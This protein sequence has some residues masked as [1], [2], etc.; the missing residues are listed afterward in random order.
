LRAPT[1][2]GIEIVRP[3]PQLSNRCLL[4][5][6]FNIRIARYNAVYMELPVPVVAKDSLLCWQYGGA[7]ARAPFTNRP[8]PKAPA[9]SLERYVGKFNNP[10]YGD[11]LVESDGQ[12]LWMTIGPHKLK[13]DLIHWNHDSF[14]VSTPATDAF[15]GDSGSAT[16]SFAKD[17]KVSL[18]T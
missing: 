7:S 5:T 10:V 9:Q 8:S 18:I 6:K 3:L 12:K 15:L 4:S 17:G 13:M 16:F 2:A 14:A 1:T 11:L